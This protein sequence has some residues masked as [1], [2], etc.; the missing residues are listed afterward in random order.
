MK[1]QPPGKKSSSF[2]YSF[3]HPVSFALTY[4]SMD[5][6]SQPEETFHGGSYVSAGNISRS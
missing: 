4:Y 6:L 3:A 5:Y 1:V 2:V